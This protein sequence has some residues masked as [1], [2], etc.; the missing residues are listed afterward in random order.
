VINALKKELKPQIVPKN[1]NNNINN[2]NNNNNKIPPI[3]MGKKSSPT[4]PVSLSQVH[5]NPEE[6]VEGLD[7]TL[8]RFIHIDESNANKSKILKSLD[9]NS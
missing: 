1:I 4:H 6:S 7:D 5:F 9:T 3:L 2:N 8:N